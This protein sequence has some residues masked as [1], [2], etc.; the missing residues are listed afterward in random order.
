ME[1]PR[2]LP[3]HEFLA[4]TTA[5]VKSWRENL[6]QTEPNRQ[7]IFS[8]YRA[9]SDA[10]RHLEPG[11]G[12]G[13]LPRRSELDERRALYDRVAECLAFASVAR[14]Q[15]A[16]LKRYLTAGRSRGCHSSP[17]PHEIELLESLG[18]R[19]RES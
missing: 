5:L 16:A 4:Q 1:A 8:D 7:R 6:A 3:A 11:I 18:E 2:S 10:L 19:A 14:S 12:L 13:S 15:V 17:S 9:L